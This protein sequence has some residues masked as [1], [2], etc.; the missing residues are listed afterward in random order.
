M[1]LSQ[2]TLWVCLLLAALLS[3]CS[4]GD[5][6][7]AIAAS[8]FLEAHTY[9][10]VNLAE[11]R[12]D[13]VEVS[14]GDEVAQGQTLVQ[15]SL[16]NLEAQREAAAA[17]VAQAEAELDRLESAPTEAEVEG[18]TAELEA[19]Q[20]DLL[21]AET[22]LELLED[23]YEPGQPPERQRVPVQTAVDL[24]QATVDLAQARLDQAQAGTRAEELHVAQAALDEARAV[25]EMVELQLEYSDGASPVD[26]VV[27]QVGL[28]AGEVVA[29]GALIATV[30]DTRQ[31]YIVVYLDQEQVARIGLGD[32]AELSVDAYPDE[33]FQGQVTWIAE[34]AQFTPSTVQ[35]EEERI[36]LVFAVRIEISNSDGRLIAGLPAD[37][38][39]AP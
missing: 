8:G 5:S 33:V 29:P 4:S 10:I 11:G 31:L 35:T 23:A 16:P 21:E 2:R 24:A 12:V 25:L 27:Q 6:D 20:V 1:K 28:R 9:R 7:Q 19:A 18:L 34:E 37:V 38:V 17:A 22:Q 15:L 3:A 26:G 36:S 13:S 32:E 39:I 30:A 14:A